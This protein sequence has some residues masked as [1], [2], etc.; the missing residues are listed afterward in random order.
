MAREGASTGGEEM[1]ISKVKG[2]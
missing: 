2:F 1:K